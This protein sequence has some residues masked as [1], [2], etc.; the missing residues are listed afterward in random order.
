MSDFYSATCSVS[1]ALLGLWW[2][3]VQFKYESWLRNPQRRGRAYLIA[4]MFLLP[5]IMSLASLASERLTALW[6]VGF[7]IAGLVGLVESV[8]SLRMPRRDTLDTVLGVLTAVAYLVVTIIA[9]VPSLPSRLGIDL[10]GREAEA[11]AV[12]CLLVLGTTMVWR[13]FADPSDLPGADVG[14]T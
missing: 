1:F 4:L 13:M 2:V 14:A 9:L 7:G 5:G 10:L 8:R 6:Q 3:V 11:I 12:T